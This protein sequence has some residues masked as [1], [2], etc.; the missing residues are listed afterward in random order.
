MI[1][2]RR[3]T[4]NKPKEGKF[5][6]IVYESSCELA[7]LLWLG[8]LKKEGYVISIDRCPSFLLSDPI[9]TNY[10]QQLKKGSKAVQQVI[11]KGHTYTPDYMVRFSEKAVGRFIWVDRSN[12]K[13][14]RGLLVVHKVDNQYITYIEVKPDFDRNNTTSR[15]VND[16]K[17]VYQKY[18]IFINLFKPEH[19]FSI[20]FTPLLYLKTSTGKVKKLKYN[21]R[22][23]KQYINA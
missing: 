16:M 2:N 11:S 22:S 9:T 23:L 5:D 19:R 1:K 17:W 14:E 10:A 20:T 15:A 3:K 21:P 8:E 13:W 6:G 18:G 12:S 7:V 4:D